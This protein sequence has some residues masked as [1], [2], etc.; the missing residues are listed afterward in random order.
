MAY[1]IKSKKIFAADKI[2]S[3]QALIIE[4]NR[5]KGFIKNKKLSSKNNKIIDYGDKIIIP[6]L[7]D[8]HI[9]GAV[10]KD[11]MDAEYDS[12]NDISK[13]LAENGVTSFLATTLT[14]PLF[15][16][17]KAL[18]NINKTMEKGVGGAEILGAYL[19][20]PYL[21]AE[22]KGAHPPQYMRD[23]N[24]KEIKKLIKIS[25][26]R[27]K[28]FALAPEKENSKEIIE[29]LEKNNIRTTIAHTNADYEEASAAIEN[30]LKLAT[31]TYN[32]MKGLHHREPGS[33]G[34]ILNHENVYS[35]I[36]ADNIH[37]HPAALELLIKIKGYDKVI[38]ISDCMQAGGLNDGQY[39][40]GE[41]KVKVENSTARTESGS[42]AG[43][44][45]NL[46]DAVIN[47][48]EAAKIDLYSAVKMAAIVP[49]EILGL[50]E[51]I[52]SIKINK[53]A[54]L[55]VVDEEMNIFTT[56][57]NGKIVYQK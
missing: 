29:F 31:H 13:Y 9:H 26:N 24:L 42:L 54:N 37:V 8:L 35:E 45:L 36:I 50:E 28:V 43:S 21:T 56:I 33:L 6:G 14:A 17:N 57:I 12:L 1:Y 3:D 38:L 47:I 44:T 53:K 20:G 25:N 41:L 22:H 15:K 55:A 27:I 11:V 4:N 49:A 34:A 52:G 23:L 10:G 40:L 2:L 16:I 30:G 39:M 48:K 5:I 19:E 46:K 51:E 32:G 18:A 7:I